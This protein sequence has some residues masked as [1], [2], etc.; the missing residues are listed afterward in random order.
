M[1]QYMYANYH[2]PCYLEFTHILK[3]CK[4][5]FSVPHALH[6]ALV[7][8]HG[9]AKGVAQSRAAVGHGAVKRSPPECCAIFSRSD[10]HFK[11]HSCLIPNCHSH[12]RVVVCRYVFLF[13]NPRHEKA[14]SRRRICDTIPVFSKCTCSHV[15]PT[16][17][18]EVGKLRNRKY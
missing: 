16:S 5:P 14:V 13:W 3:K 7:L 6:A 11:L 1:V 4:Q 12:S 8:V 10:G 2:W 17:G 15:L 18:R 9:T